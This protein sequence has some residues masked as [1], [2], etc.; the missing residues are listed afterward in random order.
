MRIFTDYVGST[1]E[2]GS[3]FELIRSNLSTVKAIIA[4]ASV[5]GGT[6]KSTMAVNLAAALAL[7]GRKV[8][9][10]DG[11]LNAPSVLSMLGMKPPRH[12]PMLEGIEPAA[13]PH[14]LRIVSSE[15]LPGG[16]PPPVSFISD[17]AENNGAVRRV[18]PIE[19]NE[20]DALGRML[21]QARLG[22]LD[23]LV[24]DL[25]P[26]LDRLH[27]LL[28]MAPVSGALLLTHTS[29]MAS[30]AMRKAFEYSRASGI[31]F[32]GVVENMAGFNCEECRSVRPLWPEGEV[33]SI[34][35]G[36][37]VRLLGRIAFDPR[38]AES[39]D[40]GFL[41]VR[42]HAATPT[43]KSLAEM[44]ALLETLLSVRTREG[45]PTQP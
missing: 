16:E 30:A 13:G 4:V 9:I 23:L 31:N 8:A 27:S 11:D 42:E 12:L 1:E 43:G 38:L 25:G 5:K 44:A 24:I 32:V 20:T 45:A 18:D 15:M 22:V 39:A 2:S 37:S 6:G 19:M 7:K 10:V 40:R 21:S 34:A 28:R 41:F 35:A 29:G 33:A 17:D 14:G 36:A 26:G 3:L